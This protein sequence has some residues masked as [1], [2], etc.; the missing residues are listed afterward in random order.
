LRVAYLKDWVLNIH[1]VVELEGPSV[2]RPE[3]AL[4]WVLT[5]DVA[6]ELYQELERGGC[7]EQ[8]EWVIIRIYDGDL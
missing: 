5:W 4:T 2:V 3:H 7:L 6:R 8:K 1:K